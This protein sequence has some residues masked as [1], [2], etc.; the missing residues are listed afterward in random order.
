MLSQSSY[1]MFTYKSPLEFQHPIL[2]DTLE[3]NLKDLKQ[4]LDEVPVT[5]T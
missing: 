1:R 5:F 3:S 2:L 4:V